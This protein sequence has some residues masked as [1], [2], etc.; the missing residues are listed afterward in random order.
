MTSY[1][2]PDGCP[3]VY[4]SIKAAMY[5]PCDQFDEHGREKD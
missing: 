1:P 3:R 5:C 4:S 2:C